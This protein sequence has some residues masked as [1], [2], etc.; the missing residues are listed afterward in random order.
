MAIRNQGQLSLH[1]QSFDDLTQRQRRSQTFEE[2]LS[3]YQQMVE[4][5]IDLS[6]LSN[7]QF[8]IKPEFDDSLV[9][10]RD[11]LETL[12]DNLDDIHK[13]VA[14]DLGF[15]TDGKVLHFEVNSLFGYCFRL[16]RKVSTPQSLLLYQTRECV[17][18]HPVQE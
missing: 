3:T 11:K 12:R 5:T 4:T 16:T 15:E 13:E 10:L 9:A 6:E 8:V 2:S 14:E 18:D 17:A 1:A 7:H